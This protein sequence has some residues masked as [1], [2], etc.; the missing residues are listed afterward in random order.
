MIGAQRGFDQVEVTPDD[1]VVVDVRHFLQRILDLGLEMLGRDF[2][3]GLLGRVEAR[4]EQ[5]EQ[6]ARDFRIAIEGRR[7][8]TLALRN[9]GLLEV[10]AIGPQDGDLA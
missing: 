5:R 10:A 9:A 7:D 3:L 6:R 2:G 4:D 8:E 1:G